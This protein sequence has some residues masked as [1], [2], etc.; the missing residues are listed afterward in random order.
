MYA[1]ACAGSFTFGSVSRSWIPSRTWN[2]SEIQNLIL[3]V[4]VWLW[5]LAASLSLRLRLTSKLCQTG[6]RLDEKVEARIYILAKRFIHYGNYWKSYRW[7]WIVVF[8]DH[9]NFVKAAFPERALFSRNGTFPVHQ[10]H[11]AV[12]NICL[13]TDS[14]KNTN[15]IFCRSGNKSIRLI[16]SPGFTFFRQSRCRNTRH[17]FLCLF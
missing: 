14:A 17:F 2:E 10:V 13:I 1:S 12:L 3:T 5:L 11:C 8:E 4:P 7:A 15:I 6:K 16:F 9:S